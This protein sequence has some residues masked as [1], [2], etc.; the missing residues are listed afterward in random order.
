LDLLLGGPA[1]RRAADQI[2]NGLMDLVDEASKDYDLII[3][4]SPPFLGFPEPLQM[5]SIVDG[6]L[7][8]AL[9]GQTNRRALAST[10]SS[11]KR[12]RTN[13]LGVVLNRMNSD[14]G[15]GYYYN[16]SPKNYKYYQAGAA[17]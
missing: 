6:V 3:I 15:S 16:Y 13:L 4:D 10:V 17:D 14:G 2:G 9:S 1:S 12:L 5:A 7:V 11:L 8:V